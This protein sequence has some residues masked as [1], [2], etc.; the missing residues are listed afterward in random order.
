MCQR[1]ECNERDDDSGGD[2]NE[3]NDKR[4]EIAGWYDNLLSDVGGVNVVSADNLHI[5]K[6]SRHLYQILVD[7]N[8]RDGIINY[9]YENEIYPGVHYIDNTLYPMYFNSYGTCPNAHQYSKQLIT[10]PIHLDL[11]YKDCEKII[12]SLGEIL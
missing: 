2:L 1:Y 5:H 4:N 10:L 6:S 9:F 11:K 12:Q 8:K 7:E 3:D